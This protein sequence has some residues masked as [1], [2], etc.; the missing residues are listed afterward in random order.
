MTSTAGSDPWVVAELLDL[1][2]LLIVATRWIKV[3][4]REAARID[5]DLDA[6]R[7]AVGGGGEPA[8]D[9]PWWL[10]DPQLRDRY[11]G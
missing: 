10:D 7:P 3:D 1:P 8:Q 5:A 4:A 6:R 11:H 2:F 9:R